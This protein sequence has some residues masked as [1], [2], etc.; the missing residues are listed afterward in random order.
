MNKIIESYQSL[1]VKEQKM[2]Q[3]ASIAII[4]FI[5]YQFIFM[6]FSTSLDK[7]DKQLQYQTELNQ[8][9]KK[10]IPDRATTQNKKKITLTNSELLSNTDNSIKQSAL[11][12]FQY[13][14]SQSDANSV[15][16][17]FKNVPY[18]DYINWLE[19]IF[20]QRS[21]TVKEININQLN[22]TGMIKSTLHFGLS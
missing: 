20:K 18:V 21:L 4:L 15:Q 2:I 12:T 10:V 14:L 8:W 3:V 9:L 13:E 16:L 11:S 22:E 5:I 19:K 6:P 7:M 17:T 1:E